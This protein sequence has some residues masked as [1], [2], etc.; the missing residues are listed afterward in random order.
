MHSQF[1]AFSSEAW[2]RKKEERA[3]V[4]NKI[5]KGKDTIE[6]PLATHSLLKPLEEGSRRE[7]GVRSII[8]AEEKGKA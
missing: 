5:R 3:D 7:P 8:E 4:S 1:G 2:P 6:V